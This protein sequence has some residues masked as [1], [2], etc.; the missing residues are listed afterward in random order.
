MF[1]IKKLIIS[2]TYGKYYISNG[3]GM[4]SNYMHK[5]GSIHNN[6]GTY[7]LFKNKEEAQIVLDHYNFLQYINTK[8]DFIS[9]KEFRV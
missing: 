8:N 3:A 9:E 4:H 6:C 2:S 7:G 5:D 1:R